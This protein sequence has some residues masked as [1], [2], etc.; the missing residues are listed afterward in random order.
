MIDMK[1]GLIGFGA[2]GSHIARQMKKDI[3]WAVD[4]DL[5]VAARMRML[6]LRCKLHAKVPSRCAG[7]G[8]VVEAAS[9]G[10]VPMLL[11]CLPYCD[12]MIMSVGALANRRLL[13]KL[14]AA[15]KKYGRKIYLPSGAIGGLDAIA[16][17]DGKIQSVLLETVKDPK[18]LGREDRKRTVIFEGSASEACRLYPKN[19][20]VS[21]TLS[22]AGIGFEKTRV[23]IIS[24]PMVKR[25]IHSITVEAES[26]GMYFR[27]ENE[28]FAENPKTSALAALSAISRI[29]KIKEPIQIG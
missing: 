19:V 16:S 9:Q 7:V 17:A 25:N 14:Q 20:N 8:L 4:A 26:G 13:G 18:S 23:R 21:A 15:A 2:I 28:P 10:A 22:L 12:V 1:I 24:D 29:R 27:F 3:A 11:G 6:K 5:S